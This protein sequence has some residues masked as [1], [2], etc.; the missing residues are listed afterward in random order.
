MRNSKIVAAMIGAVAAGGCFAAGEN[1]TVDFTGLVYQA[2][3]AF[4]RDGSD[5]TVDLGETTVGAL[6]AGKRTPQ[7]P[8]SVR[9]TGCKLIEAGAP[10]EEGAVN[11]DLVEVTLR[12]GKR[13]FDAGINLAANVGNTPTPAYV[14]INLQLGSER[15]YMKGAEAKLKLS[16]YDLDLGQTAEEGTSLDFA[17]GMEK[18]S[19]RD[20]PVAGNIT[21]LLEL[22]F[23]YL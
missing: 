1:T 9:I 22:G 20:N 11:V 17:A 23:N 7:K 19:S 18:G 10:W 4:D 16:D 21:G 13:S 15:I 5:K 8:F 14:G 6:M 12:D 2:G 3:C